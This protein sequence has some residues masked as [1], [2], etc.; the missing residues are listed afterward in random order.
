MR[1][2]HFISPAHRK[3]GRVFNE[4][5]A[6]KVL[7]SQSTI[8]K[9]SKENEMHPKHNLTLDGFR[10]TLVTLFSRQLSKNEA[11]LL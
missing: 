10:V 11:K 1:R 7:S 5:V 4:L 6:V 2:I 9:A 3:V 8:R